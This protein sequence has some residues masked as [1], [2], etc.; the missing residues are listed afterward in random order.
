MSIIGA[1]NWQLS[2]DATAAIFGQII[3]LVCEWKCTGTCN[4]VRCF[5]FGLWWLHKYMVLILIFFI[6]RCLTRHHTWVK[7]EEYPVEKIVRH[8]GKHWQTASKF[9]PA[10]WCHAVRKLRATLTGDIFILVCLNY[11]SLF[12]G[13]QKN[14]WTLSFI[15]KMALQL[16]STKYIFLQWKHFWVFLFVSQLSIRSILSI[17]NYTYLKT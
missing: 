13:P 3:C 6:F 5:M 15:P 2:C 16:L 4:F 12:L 9:T 8:L 7:I 1:S 10:L 14:L 11:L 17:N